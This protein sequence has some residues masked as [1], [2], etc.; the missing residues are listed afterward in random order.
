ML[1]E[2]EDIEQER[3]RLS[4]RPSVRDVPPVLCAFDVRTSGE[5]SELGERVRS[6]LGP[7]LRLAESQPYEGE[8]LPVDE[9]PDW[10]SAAARGVGWHPLNSR[11]G[12]LSAMRP[13]WV[14]GRGISRSGSTSST[15]SP[16]SVAGRGGT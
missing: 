4:R 9:V 1:H 6:V 13:R 8:D 14:E 12:V 10:F 7:A 5:V 15:L 2:I 11:R 3:L 16:S